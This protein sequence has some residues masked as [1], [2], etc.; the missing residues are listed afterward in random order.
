MAIA[1]INHATGEVV[2]TFTALTVAQV[3]EKIAKAAKTFKTYRKT[4]FADRARWMNKA[5]DI[6]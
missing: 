4:S 2:K 3:D 5:A 6:L 1:S